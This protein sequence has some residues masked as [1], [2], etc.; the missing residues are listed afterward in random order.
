MWKA[1]WLLSPEP[2]SA[3]INRGDMKWKLAM[4]LPGYSTLW[5]V[6]LSA[7]RSALECC[8]V[9]STWRRRPV[10]LRSHRILLLL[11]WLTAQTGM[12]FNQLVASTCASCNFSYFWKHS[13]SAFM[14]F[15]NCMRSL[16]S[17]SL[18]VVLAFFIYL[19]F[20]LYFILSLSTTINMVRCRIIISA[21]I[22]ASGDAEAKNCVASAALCREFLH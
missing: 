4:L 21:F 10:F 16:F 14:Y 22:D 9:Q 11:A 3:L 13:A 7:L 17:V 18:S 6:P 12:D 20:P 8:A 19:H 15:H 1:V 2:K 5:N